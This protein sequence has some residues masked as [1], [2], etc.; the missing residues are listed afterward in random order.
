VS[1]CQSYKLRLLL[2]KFT[3]LAIVL[4]SSPHSIA[5]PSYVGPWT[6]YAAGP[7]YQVFTVATPEEG[8]ARVLAL[9]QLVYVGSDFE[10][11]YCNYRVGEPLAWT[12]NSNRPLVEGVETNGGQYFYIYFQSNCTSPPPRTNS[13]YLS[14]IARERTVCSSAQMF[15]KGRCEDGFWGQEPAA[16]EKTAGP[17]NCDRGKTLNQPVSVGQPI[18]PNT[19]NMWHVE[20]DYALG[21]ASEL[22]LY[23]T[24]NS[25]PFIQRGLVKNGFGTRWSHN[26][27]A[28]L[29]VKL[30][31][32]AKEGKCWYYNGGRF[33][34]CSN[35]AIPLVP[36]PLAVKIARGDGK[37]FAFQ[38]KVD[39]T[40]AGDAD[41]N[42]KLTATYNGDR[43]AITSWTYLDATSGDTET[44][45]SGGRLILIAA[46][47]GRT[48]RLTY[49]TGISN[50]TS[51]E[52]YPTDAPS[53]SV[54]QD[55]AILAASRLL[56]VTD[57]YGRQ[58]QFKYDAA[59]RIAESID[60]AGH[61]TMYEYD[62]PSGGCLD[63]S[64]TSIACTASNLTKVT[65]PD[66]KSRTYVYNEFSQINSGRECTYYPPQL[67]PT[68]GH[69][70]NSLTGLIDENGVRY[71]NWGYDCLGRAELSELANGVE[72]VTL[73]YGEN[74]AGGMTTQMK[75]FLGTPAAPQSTQ[76]TFTATTIVGAMRN[77]SVSGPCVECGP[78]ALRT[79]DSNGNI[80]TA[81]DFNGVQTNF[82]YDL[83]RNLELS[84]TEAFGTLQERTT[85]STWH[86]NYRLPTQV[87]SPKRMDT[88]TYDQ[89]GNLLSRSEQATTDATG[90][91][92]LAAVVTGPARTWRYAY[93]SVGNILRVTGPRTDVVDQTNYLY[94]S[95]GNLDTV[96]NPLNQVTRYS[97]YDANGRVGRT[98]AANGSVTDFSYS[99]RGWLSRR[100]VTA[101]G[102]GVFS[103]F[104]Y[105]GV[106]QLTKVTLPDTSWV[107]YEY[108]GAHRL[109]A[110]S[111]N[112]GNRITYTLDL[113]GNRIGERT[114]DPNGVLRRQVARAF[115]SMNRVSQ[116][117]GA[118]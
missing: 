115:D 55:G 3:L 88:Y 108:D 21:G 50:D 96:T 62:G 2:W 106:G 65:Y 56:C 90:A 105:D 1:N 97:N 35:P 99:V 107:A 82:T 23:R 85:T 14:S 45:D 20:H 49:S 18:N 13:E 86:P 42:D 100:T 39:G 113:T 76:S 28:S 53:C 68:T 52:R 64:T 69:L 34:D 54:V 95:Y 89:A 32:A 67:T 114:S 110:M 48:Q 51:A 70:P 101:G 47:R 30:M 117:T 59:G 61:S 27:E 15:I 57:D 40:W 60:P 84:H 92:G 74:R 43:S 83:A 91:S 77:T 66:G 33:I 44:I 17:C 22:Q 16:N 79:Y 41:V 109:T 98:T 103:D 94:D 78:Y 116:Q 80:I 93:D 37:T 73:G 58:L 6:Y 5:I 75:H 26:Y 24:Y 25:A 102:I 46:R 4:F 11:S 12:T 7:D 72:K 87:A 104:E 9:L 19:G 8:R 31:D 10:R 81:T 112:V 36:I 118:N 29:S 71:I 63:G 111:D 38:L